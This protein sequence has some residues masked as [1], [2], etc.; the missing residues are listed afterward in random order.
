MPSRKRAL[1][2]VSISHDYAQNIGAGPKSQV[3]LLVFIGFRFGDATAVEPA[4]VL[5]ARN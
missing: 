5:E 1:E 4:D 3:Y 2:C